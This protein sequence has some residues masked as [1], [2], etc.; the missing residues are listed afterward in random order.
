MIYDSLAAKSIKSD[1]KFIKIYRA[2]EQGSVKIN[3]ITL[4]DSMAFAI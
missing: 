2:H 1:H 4:H 3:K